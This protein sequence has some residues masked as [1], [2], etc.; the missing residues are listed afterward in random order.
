MTTKKKN[1]AKKKVVK[2]SVK[3]TTS[4]KALSKKT[5]SKKKTPVKKK[6]VKL[7]AKK[8]EMFDIEKTV[9]EHLKKIRNRNF[10]ETQYPY[11]EKM[12]RKEYD[13]HKK[14]L[15]IELLKLQKWVKETGNKVVIIFEGRDAAGKGGTIKRFMEHLNPRGAKVV[16]L[17]KPTEKESGE[18]YFQRYVQ[19][20]PSAGEITLFD[21]SWYN[22]A[23]VEKVMN[24]SSQE[25]YE[26]FFKQVPLFERLLV[27]SGIHLFKFWFSVS[28][29]EQMIRFK[30]RSR[31]PLRRW[32]LS[33]VDVKSFDKWDAYTKAKEAMFYYTDSSYAPWTV[34]RSNDKKRARLNCMLHVLSQLPYDKK[35]EKVAKNPDPK[36]VFKVSEFFPVRRKGL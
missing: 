19:H 6:P 35:N 12:K 33:P 24:F 22:R 4:K 5:A 1:T 2:K 25:Q 16:A 28:R 21:R 36:I 13:A 7:T 32:K 17:D 23:G 34:I 31:D 8:H 14:N 27:E 29:K 20:L 3:K 18:W 10:E 11:K 15:Q 26:L 9:D 30:R